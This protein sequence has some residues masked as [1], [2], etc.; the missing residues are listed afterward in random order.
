[1]QVPF[2]DLSLIHKPIQN[3]LEKAYQEVLDESRFIN[4]AS[5]AIFEEAFAE[6]CGV[7][8]C[9]AVANCTDALYIALKMMGVGHEDEVILP[10]MTW[11]SDAEVVTQLGAKPVFVDIDPISY[12]IDPNCIERSINKRTKAIIPVHLYGQLANIEEINSVAD[13]HNLKVIEDC[14]QSHFAQRNGKMA[15]SFADASVFSFYPSKNLGALGDAGC[16]LTNDE[17]LATACRKFANHGGIGKD[18]HEFPGVNSRM[19]TL[20][21]AILS[22]KLQHIDEWTSARQSIA[23]QY[24][25]GLK[26]ID[27]LKLPSMDDALSHVFHIFLIQTARRD[28]LKRFLEERGIQT[29][30]HY[31]KAIPFTEAYA[32]LGFKNSDFPVSY[33]LQEECLSLPIYPGL[34][35]SQI[36]YVVDSVCRFYKK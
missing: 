23:E 27:D 16:I 28:D 1:M 17:D 32:H 36:K 29:Q 8:H 7:D 34:T 21:A 24:L 5:V 13:Q 18:E 6:K 33:E 12:T 20:Q 30:I 11:I 31:P 15:G 35:T 25:S 19:D 22:L 9:V 3:E 14:A 26:G 4:G 10:A 2:L